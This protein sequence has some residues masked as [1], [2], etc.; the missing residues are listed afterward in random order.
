MV[1]L[2]TLM[3]KMCKKNQSSKNW[4]L[5]KKTKKIKFKSKFLLYFYYFFYIYF[6]YHSNIKKP[7]SHI[8]Q[9]HLI[10]L[11]PIKKIFCSIHHK[12]LLKIVP[13]NLKTLF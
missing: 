13:N 11:Y 1:V 4:F 9:L 6:F 3:T 2:K 5:K 7:Q 12:K 10:Q 8:E